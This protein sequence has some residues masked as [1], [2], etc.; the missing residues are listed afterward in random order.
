[1]WIWLFLL[2]NH[3]IDGSKTTNYYPSLHKFSCSFVK[4]FNPELKWRHLKFTNHKD[5]NEDEA[6]S[7]DDEEGDQVVFQRQTEVWQED[8]VAAKR[9][10]E[11]CQ[12]QDR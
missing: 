3:Q 12:V 6:D 11:R 1:M 2:L 8:H 9:K 5:H 10:A 7:H 4:C